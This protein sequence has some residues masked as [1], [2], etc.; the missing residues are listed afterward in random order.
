MIMAYHIINEFGQFVKSQANTP[1]YRTM[2]P[3]NQNGA[4]VVS[5]CLEGAHEQL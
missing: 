5:T 1:G 2:A 3:A 4:M